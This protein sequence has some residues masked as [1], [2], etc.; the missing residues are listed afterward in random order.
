MVPGAKPHDF[1]FTTHV[2]YW[3]QYHADKAATLAFTGDDDV[4][5]FINNTLAVDLGGLH[6]PLDGSVT[7]NA[8]TAATFG[9][10]DGGV[11]KISVFHAE[12]KA[13]ARA[14]SSP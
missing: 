1:S 9:L 11:Y 10:K 5:V 14:S 8:T 3:F 2:Q 6:V 4:W 7:I 12:R 13:M